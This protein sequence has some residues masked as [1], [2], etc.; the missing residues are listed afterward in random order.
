MTLR[1]KGFRVG[2]RKKLS[3]HP[4][5]RGKVSIRAFLRKYRV[6]EAVIIT[7]EP[8]YNKGM[9]HKRYMGDHGKI[10]EVRGRAYM[11]QVKD[12]KSLKKVICSPIHL[13]RA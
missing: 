1:T 3:K 4:R 8:A 6:G 10:V 12:G 11:V 7:P 9:P 5:D 2:T 13:K